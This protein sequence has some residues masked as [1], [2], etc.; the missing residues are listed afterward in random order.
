MNQQG[1]VGAA[2][3][4]APPVWRIEPW[5][6]G[7]RARTREVWQY[8][9]LGVFFAL[10][11]LQK[12][13]QRTKLGWA[14][15]F[16]RP[17][18]PLLVQTIIFGGML[19]VASDGVPYFL[20]LVT[21]STIWQLFASAVLWGTRSLELNRG[22]MKQIYV[23]RLIMPVSMMSPAALTFVIYLAV[24]AV[25]LIWYGVAHRH[26]YLH[27]GPELLLAPLA[28]VMAVALALAISLWT[29]VPALSARDVRFSLNYVMSFWIFLT[30]VMYPMSAVP[31]RWRFWMMFNPMA[32][33]V[34]AFK[35]GLLGI[36]S[37][38]ARQLGTAGAL[39]VAVL[40]GGLVFFVRAEADAADRV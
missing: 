17:L 12:L 25:A 28:V 26:L 3:A 11:A 22:L 2:S 21:A 13:Y 1:D 10:K 5:T 6:G 31:E 19:K 23:P 35:V 4:E 33:I 16:I 40:V 15:L 36:G 18:F 37:I 24:L 8:R 30:P 7:I 27:I 34:E 29:S 39:I 20:F 14:W 32:P 9:R 38:D